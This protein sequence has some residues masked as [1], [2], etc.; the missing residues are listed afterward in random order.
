M[1]QADL[2]IS[3]FPRQAESYGL[4]LRFRHPV[5]GQDKSASGSF[6]LDAAELRQRQHDPVAYGEQL[7]AQL[8]ASPGVRSFLDQAL[9]VAASQQTSLHLRLFISADAPD[10]HSLRWETLRLPGS[11]APLAAGEWLRFSRYLDS[12]GWRPARTVER[13]ALRALVAV[14]SPDV[15]STTLA[16]VRTED[17]LRA[18]RA[19][20]G[21]IPSEALAGRGQ[22]TLANLLA[23]LRDGCDILYLVAHGMLVDGEP[24]ILL[25][26]EDGGRAWTSGRELAAR[27]GELAQPPGLVLLVSCQSAGSGGESTHDGGALA[28]L[29]PRLAAAG[30]PA[31]VAMQGNLT[32]ATA[33]AF[34]PVFLRELRRDGQVDRAMAVARGAVRERPDWW[35]PVLYTR[36]EDGRVFDLTAM[37]P[38][39]PCPYPGMVPFRAEDSRFFYGREG[40]IQQMLDHL[41]Q[42]R[43]LLVIGPSGSGKS[44]LI[45]AGLLPRLEK[46]TYFA[47]G[48]WLVRT[49]RPLDH[50][51][52]ALAACLERD[53][54]QPEQ[55]VAALLAAHA[56]AQRLLLVIDQFEEAFS[57]ADKTER[58]Q[59]MAALQALRRSQQCA[60]VIAL[61]ADFYPDLMNSDL[62]PVDPGQRLDVTG[63]RGGA[64]RQAI[65]QPASDVE[66]EIDEALAERLLADAAGEPGALP[67][68][69]ETLV[70]LWERMRRRQITLGDYERLGEGERSG[71]AVAVA[72]KADATVAELTPVEQLVAQRIFLRLIQFGEGRRDTRRQLPAADLHSA[73]DDSQA[74]ERTLEHLARNRLLTLSG[75][76]DDASCRVDISH[77]ALISD[78]PRLQIWLRERKEAELA[79]RR[80]EDKSK[81]WVRL[82]RGEGG[83]LD[84]EEL[85]E[86]D[87]WLAGQ[88]S[89][90]RD[91]S[92]AL[93]ALVEASRKAINPGWHRKGVVA[94]TA[95]GI[96]ILALAALLPIITVGLAWPLRSALFLT[97]GL[98]L[99][100]LAWSTGL[101]RRNDAY[102]LQHLS[103]A[104]VERRWAQPLLLLL[105]LVS[106]ASWAKF[107]ISAVRTTDY[108]SSLGYTDASGKTIRVAVSAS[109]LDPYYLKLVRD[110]IETHPDVHS[111]I[112]Q[113]ND[114]ER[115]S[116][117]FSYFV[118]LQRDSPPGGEEIGYSAEVRRDLNDSP[119]RELAIRSQAQCDLFVEIGQKVLNRLPVA[120]N[121]VLSQQEGHSQIASCQAFMQN[122]EGYAAYQQGNY[123]QARRLL[124]ETITLEPG[125][126]V[127]HNNLG[128]VHLREG[129]YN[130]AYTEFAEAVN[131]WPANGLFLLNQGRACY[132]LNDYECA[133]TSYRQSIQR[134]MDNPTAPHVLFE[135]YHNLS[136]LYREWDRL[137]AADQ[138]LSEATSLLGSIS[139]VQA[140]QQYELSLLKNRGILRFQERRWDDAIELLLDAKA[141]DGTQRWTEEILYYL[142][143]A[144]ESTADQDQACVNWLL[145][146]ATPSAGLFNES[147]RRRDAAI[148]QSSLGCRK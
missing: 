27:I 4:A 114:A 145:Y 116:R 85:A 8:F 18:A 33:A 17:E 105:T 96:A 120:P 51:V 21:D 124:Q 112:V 14:A 75:E 40:E 54:S 30:V 80:F 9:A 134:E 97:G 126:A 63:L 79:R 144:Y 47:P 15:G 147:E 141:F 119:I 109:D 72:R 95:S 98:L 94:L 136:V 84:K 61:R 10:L 65:R 48:F 110:E 43:L 93:L 130:E 92:A 35:M 77:E 133:E 44:S 3:L 59:L 26:R 90:E 128:L 82:G 20:L 23:R 56:P 22:V 16:E 64:L 127:A 7:A 45:A 66:V 108:C 11:A 117:Y 6:A 5:A 104:V 78:W 103:Q 36:L 106:I 135:A 115:C 86:V 121:Q 83:M 42:Q 55:A 139:D 102:R 38:P 31:V 70:L 118:E 137:A 89:M 146:N 88:G 49:M 107:G 76:E 52:A 73:A 57:L 68:L 140:R 46:S 37:L 142:A 53:V 71:L 60:L 101:L 129:N 25:E 81:E 67:M 132:R 113:I 24:Q 143:L 148:H 41:R 58:Q 28:G 39:P 12:A 13:D 100:F 50:P 19:G 69:Q 2:E 74:F 91:A 29:G 122:Q 99:V 125:F 87:D 123:A 1:S 131:L 138:T 32:M 34:M 62:W 111:W